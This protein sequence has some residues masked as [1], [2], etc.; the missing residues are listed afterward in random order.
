MQPILV[1]SLLLGVVHLQ[2]TSFV[3]FKQRME[4]K[5]INLANKMAE[6]YDRRCESSVK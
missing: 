2:T 4:S 1:L 6:V 5:T 3:Q